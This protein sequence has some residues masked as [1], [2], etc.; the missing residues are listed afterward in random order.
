MIIYFI[1]LFYYSTEVVTYSLKS[2]LAYVNKNIVYQSNFYQTQM[3][4]G[5][6]MFSR[7]HVHNIINRYNFYTICRKI[8]VDEYYVQDQVPKEPC[9][10]KM[11]RIITKEPPLYYYDYSITNRIEFVSS[12]NYIETLI[13]LI[14]QAYGYAFRRSNKKVRIQKSES[15]ICQSQ[16]SN[17]LTA[18][19][20]ISSLPVLVSNKIKNSSMKRKGY[21]KS[22]SFVLH[23]IKSVVTRTNSLKTFTESTVFPV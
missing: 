1:L 21:K 19:N 18:S 4:V 22:K 9:M 2:F 16:N 11:L 6:Y 13:F 10:N 5:K 12:D 8:S 3:I 14:K 20:N 17:F 7:K 15:S 23:E